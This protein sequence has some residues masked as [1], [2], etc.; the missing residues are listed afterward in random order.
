MNTDDN[1][2]Q[3]FYQNLGKL[4]YAVASID[5]NV[6]DIEIET[7]KQS[8]EAEWSSEKEASII[9]NM[10]DWLHKDQEYNANTCF[11]SFLN[12]MESHKALF[13]ASRKASILKTART[14]AHSFSRNNKS[15]LILLAQ[16][17]L[18]LK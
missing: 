2:I 12:Y 3:K 4:F 10:F 9:I 17:N 18:A 15:E 16:L 13:T 6:E 1:N 11:K 5:G 14:V 8:V 7:L